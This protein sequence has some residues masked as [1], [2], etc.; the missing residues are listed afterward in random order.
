MI[1][2]DIIDLVNKEIDGV[3]SSEEAAR[4]KSVLATDPE[5]QKLL[6][7]MQALA[8]AM[9]T[10]K[11]VQPPP[12]LK[13]AIVRSLEDLNSRRIPSTRRP[14]ILHAFKGSFLWKPGYAFACGLAL[15]LL[16]FFL[17]TNLL[18]HQ[19]I[20]D[21]ELTGTLVLHGQV[22]GFAPGEAIAINRDNVKGSIETHFGSNVCLVRLRMEAPEEVTVSIRT[23]PARVHLDAIR[24]ASESGVHLTVGNGELTLIGTKGGAIVALFAG[25]EHPIPPAQIKIISAGRSIFDGVISL[26]KKD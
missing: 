17:T 15:G 20:G 12:T 10:V 21:S 18:T 23:D 24:P 5:V 11:G 19:S 6:E 26:E 14:S 2:K 16:L 9:L 13:P 22:P 1:S 7:E 8:H 3:A 4:L 25:N